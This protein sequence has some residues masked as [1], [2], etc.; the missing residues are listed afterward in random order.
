M[1]GEKEIALK[2]AERAIRL[3]PS[4]KDAV[5]GPGLEENMPLIQTLFGQ[6]VD[7]AFR[8]LCDEKQL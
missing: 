7:P 6:N 1:I 5:D 3:L 2:D 4:A 8:K